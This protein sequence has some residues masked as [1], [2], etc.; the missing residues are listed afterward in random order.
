MIAIET[1]EEGLGSAFQSAGVGQWDIGTPHPKQR[2][3]QTLDADAAMVKCKFTEALFGGAT[4]GGKSWTLLADALQY[5]HIPHYSAILFRR[6]FPELK[7]E[8]GLISLAH[9]KLS[10]TSAKWNEQDKTYTFPSG[11]TLKFGYMDTE[12]DKYRYQGGEYQFI[13][14]DELTQFTESQYKYM[15]SRLRKRAEIS[16]PLRVRSA[17][18]PGG[19][20]GQWVYERFIPE[21]FTPI[22][23]RE[24]RIWYKAQEN[25]H[26]TAFVPS[27]LDDNP[28]L[29]RESYLESLM[30][31]DEITRQ[32]YISGD[33]LIQ[34]R[35]DILYTYSEA[36]TVITWEQFASVFGGKRIPAHW[37]LGV[38]QDWGTTKDHPCVTSWFATASQNAPGFDGVSLAGKV[39]LY[40]G[41][42]LTQCTAFEVAGK[43]KTIMQADGEIS[44]TERWQMSHEASSER[45]EYRRQGL[46]FV[47]WVTG[48][49]RGI[50]QLKNAFALTD[51][52][53]PHP[54]KPSLRGCPSLLLIVDSSELVNPKTDLGLVRHRAEI[55]SYSWAKLKTGDVMTRLEP[56][57]L[58]NDAIDGARAA[59]ADYF[60]HLSPL[61]ETERVDAL[62]PEEVKKAV[63][64][65]ERP[66]E[67]KLEYEFHRNLAVEQLY[68]QREFE[69]WE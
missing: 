56:Y 48:K 12:N 61:T 36:H 3:F 64:S 57:A 58:F 40:R 32:Q 18:N 65:R 8:G 25:D 37:K 59:A 60:P 53:K 6:T 67:S 47:A 13:G 26:I 29:D 10:Q 38:Y 28:S 19:I 11:A 44:R 9:E 69:D 2:L 62:I 7:Q 52:D 42:M 24:L 15:L 50:E 23:A 41:M 66:L 39:F 54:F 16:V 20:G 1:F 51:T 27:L 63:E 31:L 35:G 5:V 49:T 22:K 33:W 4:G 34:I 21:D 30:Q 14:F 46:P 55:P 45:I 68:P 43:I 17:T